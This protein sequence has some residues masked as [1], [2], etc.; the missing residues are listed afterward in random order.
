[1]RVLISALVIVLILAVPVFS[2][3]NPKR[4]SSISASA[5][6][7]SIVIV[8][9]RP[10]SQFEK[11]AAEAL[12]ICLRIYRWYGSVEIKA[13]ASGNGQTVIVCQ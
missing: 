4:Q 6:A 8:S 12:D 10:E 9:P 1:M 11:V 5:S 13:V 7:S 2:Q 3:E